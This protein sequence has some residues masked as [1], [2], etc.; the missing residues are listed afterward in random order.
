MWTLGT[1]LLV[2][3]LRLCASSVGGPGSNP[4]Q[5][6]KISHAAQ[7]SQKI[8][9]KKKKSMDSGAKFLDSVRDIVTNSNS[10]L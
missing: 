3:W 9:K 5:G 2:Q 1:S 10:H 8:K 6:T 7:H 4:G